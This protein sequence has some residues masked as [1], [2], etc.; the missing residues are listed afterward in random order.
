VRR[1]VAEESASER[2]HVLALARAGD[3]P[4]EL[5]SEIRC[6][7]STNSIPSSA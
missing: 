7:R 1:A 6:A 4:R 3:L 2:V 5:A